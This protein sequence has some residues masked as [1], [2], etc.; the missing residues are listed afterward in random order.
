MR[1]QKQIISSLFLILFVSFGSMAVESANKTSVNKDDQKVYVANKPITIDADNQ[2]IDIEKNILTFSGNVR[3]VQDGLTI[4]ADR[5][6]ITDMQDTSKQKITGYGNPVNFKQILPKN[7]RIVTGHSNQIIYNV[8]E[9]SVVLQGDAE[10]I[11]QDNHIKSSIIS[12]DV[13]KQVIV[14]EPGKNNRVKTTII[15]S[16]VKGMNK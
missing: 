14:A 15:P 10:I 2:Q 4:N 12:Y 11:Q 3:I 9:N 5:V 6:T 16:Q 1:S 13:N 7:N 8:K